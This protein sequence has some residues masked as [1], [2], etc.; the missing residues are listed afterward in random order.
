MGAGGLGNTGGQPGDL[1]GSLLPHNV[2]TLI[3]NNLQPEHFV[4]ASEQWNQDRVVN[5]S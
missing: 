5:D 4:A 2:V 3:N 1:G